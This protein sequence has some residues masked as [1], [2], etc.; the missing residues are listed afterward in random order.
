MDDAK[1]KVGLKVVAYAVIAGF[2]YGLAVRFGSHAF[3]QSS[4]FQVMS[5][6]FMVFLPIAIG[7]ITIF[8]I[9][10]QQPQPLSTWLLVPWGPVLAGGGGSAGA[11]LGGVYCDGRFT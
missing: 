8:L 9:E 3:P 1:P 6:G 4:T 7:F 2:L 10:R 5:L 11:L